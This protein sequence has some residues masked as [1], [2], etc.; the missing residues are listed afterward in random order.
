MF[1]TVAASFSEDLHI[2][3]GLPADVE[4][5]T[6]FNRRLAS[7]T[8]EIALHMPT[9][10]SGVERVLADPSLGRY[11]VALSGDRIVGQL[12]IT[13]EWSDWRDGF[14]WWL[15]SVYVE[16]EARRQGVF[17]RLFEHVVALSSREGA[18]GTRL[19]VENAND[20]A[21]ET[22]ERLGFVDA[23]YRVLEIFAALA[24]DHSEEK[25]PS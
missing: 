20:I 7:E 1:R 5:I 13:Y 17:R 12:M 10:R 21:R 16:R 6:E 14:I 19:Y 11:F 15:Q 2:R 22:Y 25:E 23:S 4:T 18:L 8:E 9:L 3:N 24:E